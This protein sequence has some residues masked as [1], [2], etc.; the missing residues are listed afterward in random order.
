M[1]KTL[2][3]ITLFTVFLA[4]FAY[5]NTPIYRGWYACKPG[6]AWT[7][8]NA[9][10][11]PHG[12]C[13][14]CDI[15][16]VKKSDISAQSACSGG[17]AYACM[18]QVPWAVND[19]LSYG[20]AVSTIGSCGWCYELTF[21]QDTA[22]SGKKMIVM[23]NSTSG[24]QVLQIDLMIPGSGAFQ[25]PDVLSRQLNANG[26]S[27]PQLGAQY[28]GF[29]RVCG[30]DAACIKNMCDAAFGT[31]ALAD[32]KA[33]CYWYVDWFNMVDITTATHTRVDCPAELVTAYKEGRRSESTSISST[34]R[35]I[36]PAQDAQASGIS[37][38][39]V[40][41]S[42][43]FTAGPNPVSKS[44]GTVSF[45]AGA[46]L[47]GACDTT[48]ARGTPPIRG[49]LT[50]YDASGNIVNK[51]SINDNVNQ[52]ADHHTPLRNPV[53]IAGDGGDCPVSRRIVGSWN[54]RDKKGRPVSEGTYLVRGTITA[55]GKKEKIS[56]MIGIK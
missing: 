10:P 24:D 32:F 11:D 1:K 25:F 44:S 47:A 20:F 53:S 56:L 19:T 51:I 33:G 27:D 5:G 34:E 42:S 35:V 55:A 3:T 8:P 30:A 29:R 39:D 45:F 54:L 31:P 12:V 13:A 14:A 18:G 37:S 17:T 50:I 6:C 16:G 40:V 9:P 23:V 48:N 28:G 36:P 41:I 15:Y 49:K 7:A 38:A 26:V 52:R 46:P 21:N 4:G 2:F 22:L 43:Q